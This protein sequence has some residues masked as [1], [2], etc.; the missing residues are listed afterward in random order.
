MVRCANVC[1]AAEKLAM[2][3]HKAMVYEGKVFAKAAEES[4]H[5]KRQLDDRASTNRTV[6]D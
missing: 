1:R 5:I 6:N 4:L 2:Q 3:L